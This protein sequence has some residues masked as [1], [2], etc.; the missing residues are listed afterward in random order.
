MFDVFLITLVIFAF[1][2]ILISKLPYRNIKFVFFIISLILAIIAYNITPYKSLDLYHHFQILNNCRAFGFGYLINH[3]DFSNLPVGALYFYIISLLGNNSFLP[4]ISVFIYYYSILSIITEVAK[5]Y[6][7]N[8]SGLWLSAVL[9]LFVSNYI[10]AASGI[11]NPLTISLFAYIFYKECFF[12]WNKK[13]V[14][15]LYI[16]LCLFHPSIL[17]LLVLRLLL[18]IPKKYS[19]IISILLLSW[20][21]LKNILITLLTKLSSIPIISFALEKFSGYDSTEANAVA[22]VSLYTFVYLTSYIILL[23]LC[24]VYYK[25]G[26]NTFE[27]HENKFN[28]LFVYTLFFCLGSILEYHIFVRFSRFAIM[29]ALF[30][31]MHYS[32][33]K[34]KNLNY[35]K[36]KLIIQFI[37]FIESVF[38]LYF[39]MNGQ[40]LSIVFS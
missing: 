14:F 24:F 27:K 21:F 17:I 11:R 9:F 19:K 31:L 18:L 10:G 35:S 26:N 22:N 38:F 13:L 4:A 28:L 29:L 39:Y 40:Y 5:K 30:L 3:S 12:G 25:R 1:L 33:S 7:F 2:Y 32:S 23:I 20:S 16:L 8:K 34:S 36:N 6:N 15:I 37:I